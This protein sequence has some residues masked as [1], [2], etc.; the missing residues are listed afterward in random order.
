MSERCYRLCVRVAIRPPPPLLQ[1]RRDITE[2]PRTV[3][4]SYGV[5]GEYFAMSKDGFDVF[6]ACGWK[7]VHLGSDHPQ[8]RTSVDVCAWRGGACVWNRA[9]RPLVGLR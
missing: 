1:Y 5:Y 3:P 8:I 4:V 7:L 2:T 6:A 9:F